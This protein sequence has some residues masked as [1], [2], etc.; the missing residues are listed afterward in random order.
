MGKWFLSLPFNICLRY[1]SKIFNRRCKNN[2]KPGLN[3][4][5]YSLLLFSRSV[6]SDS[7]WP[8][9]WQHSKLPCPS[10]PELAHSHWVS[11]TIQPSHPLLSP[12]PTAFSL[13][14]NQALFQWVGYSY[15]VATVLELQLQH[16]YF[17][18]I[19]RTDFLWDGLLG[20]PC[21]PRD[22]QESSPTP[23]F[24]SINSS[25][26]SFLYGP[27]HIRTWLLKKT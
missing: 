4:H 2:F 16:Q 21:S 24:K 3:H 12:S 10:S 17:Q 20:S 15:Q 7:L 18:R 6:V 19:V 1:C 8:H 25:A 11:D 5:Y 23:Q 26:F 9:G 13:F 14:Q 27:T 22:S